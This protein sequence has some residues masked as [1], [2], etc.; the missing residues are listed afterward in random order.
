[1]NP[2]L[3]LGI[4]SF[5]FLCI[6]NDVPWPCS[7]TPVV[8]SSEPK[9][10]RPT[11]RL[12][13]FTE[14]DILKCE[15]ITSSKRLSR[16]HGEKEQLRPTPRAEVS[17]GCSRKCENHVTRRWNHSEVNKTPFLTKLRIFLDTFL[18]S[19]DLRKNNNN[20]TGWKKRQR[21]KRQTIEGATHKTNRNTPKPLHVDARR[22]C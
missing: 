15:P 13:K 5:A 2:P 16:Y 1:M 19:V 9:L 14:N 22:G 18:C 4:L 12:L 11:K 17:C 3:D 8:H 7:K 21:R 10:W 6:L 20:V